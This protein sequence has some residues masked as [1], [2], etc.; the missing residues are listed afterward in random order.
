MI[1]NAKAVPARAERN[2]FQLCR[3]QPAFAI[4]VANIEQGVSQKSGHPHI[5]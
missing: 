2:L 4:S 3:V 5:I 1:S